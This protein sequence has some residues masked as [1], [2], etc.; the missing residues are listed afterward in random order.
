MTPAEF[1]RKWARFT[2]KESAAYQEHFND[3][4]RL[5]DF[6]IALTEAEASAYA[7]PFN[8][9]RKHVREARLKNNR[10]AY[11]NYWWRHVEPRPGMPA[12]LATLPRFLVTVRVSKHRIFTCLDAPLLPDC[13]LF[14]FA[15]ADDYFFGLLHSRI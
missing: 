15:R 8:F 9:V 2:G 13:Q 3:L 4:C 5:L 11:R 6:G 1:K 10:E 14:A 12:A 7:S